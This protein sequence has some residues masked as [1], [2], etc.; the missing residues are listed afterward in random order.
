LAHTGKIAAIG[1]IG[2]ITVTQLRMDI[3]LSKE[4]V[5]SHSPVT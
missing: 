1:K 4:L 3:M 5:C 2:K